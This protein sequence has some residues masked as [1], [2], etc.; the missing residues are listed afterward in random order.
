MNPAFSWA[1]LYS[2]LNTFREARKLSW[3]ELGAMHHISP[4]TF[5]R[6]SQDK[7]VSVSNL[8]RL[9]TAGMIPWIQ[10]ESFVK[11]PK[12]SKNPRKKV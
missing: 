4:S 5:T 3:R 12:S 2:T 10:F 7:P 6:I 1:L 9:F 11:Q 8:I